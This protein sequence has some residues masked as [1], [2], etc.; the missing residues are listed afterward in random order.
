MKN[1]IIVA[2]LSVG[3]SWVMFA[4][5]E[6]SIENK[7][8]EIINEF[9]VTLKKELVNAIKMGGPVKAIDVCKTEAPSITEA[10]S[11]KYNVNLQ[12][13]SR[14]YRNPV[15]KP[16]NNQLTILNY[17]EASES[18]V[19]NFY[20]E[21]PN[22]E[23]IY[24]KKITAGP[25]CLTCH[26]ASITPN[27][28][29][30]LDNN[31]PHDLATGYQL[32]DMRGMF[33][34]KWNAAK[35]NS[36]KANITGIDNFRKIDNKLWVGAQPSI[37]QIKQL[38]ELGVKRII[39]LRP[40]KEMTFNEE[41]IVKEQGIEYFNIS[42]SGAQDINFENSEK[43]MAL[44]NSTTSGVYLHCAS[45]NRVGAL[46][47]LNATKKGASLEEAMSIGKASGLSSLEKHVQ[48]IIIN[49]NKI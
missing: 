37:E 45:A 27:V 13:V 25:V 35:N 29:E 10:L 19:K 18:S 15:N 5:A 31:Y 33:S 23:V 47:A 32:G 21:L 9:E 48:S 16:D 36:I 34:V 7:S 46:L 26:G 4:H 40:D 11:K 22:N 30:A 8:E 28:K 17:F 2:T 20:Q 6:Q 24:A 41:K 42:I 14:K 38:K 3:F 43:V 49:Q 39:N 44:L 12:R 1:K